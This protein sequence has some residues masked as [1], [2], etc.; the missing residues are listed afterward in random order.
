MQTD[1][2]QAVSELLINDSRIINS[3]IYFDKI[4]NR[5][6]IPRFIHRGE[7][8]LR[9]HLRGTNLRNK[10]LKKSHRKKHRSFKKSKNRIQRAGPEK[11]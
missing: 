3:M 8:V 9:K 11:T 6:N 10:F 7:A 1:T 5:R 2:G 4:P